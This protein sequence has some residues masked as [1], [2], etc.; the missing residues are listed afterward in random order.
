MSKLIM[1]HVETQYFNDQGVVLQYDKYD[2][3]DTKEKIIAD[4]KN[5]AISKNSHLH[6]LNKTILRIW[7]NVESSPI[8]ECPFDRNGSPP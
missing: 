6:E 1:L 4:T 2:T 5:T 8:Y 3:E 7:S